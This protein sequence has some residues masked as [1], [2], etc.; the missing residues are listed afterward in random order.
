MFAHFARRS[1]C[2]KMQSVTLIHFFC[3]T[4]SHNRRAEDHPGV[5]FFQ[6]FL[7]TPTT[8]NKTPSDYDYTGLGVVAVFKV[9]S[10]YAG[11]TR[12]LATRTLGIP[13]LLMY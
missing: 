3:G 5:G 12:S 4:N 2:A 13:K 8:L 7:P 1:P 9:S 11:I 6:E 10:K